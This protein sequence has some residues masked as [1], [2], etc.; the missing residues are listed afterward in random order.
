M[1][2]GRGLSPYVLLGVGVAGVSYLSTRNNREKAIRAFQ[3]LKEKTM[4]L[5]SKRA[6]GPEIPLLEKAGHPDPY[7]IGDNRMVEEGAL[8]SVKYYNQKEQQA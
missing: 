2:N 1:A 3:T 4:Q 5:W 7:D 8:F 6:P